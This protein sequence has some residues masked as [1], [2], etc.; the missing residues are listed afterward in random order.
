MALRL[1]TPLAG[2]AVTRPLAAGGIAGVVGRGGPAKGTAPLVDHE[3]PDFRLPAPDGTTVELKQLRRKAVLLNFWATWYTPCK[4]ELPNFEDVYRRHKE[5]GF[6]L[7]GVRIDS[8]AAARGVP[9]YMREGGSGVGPYTFPESLDT[10]Q[11]L[12]RMCRLADVPSTFFI[13]G[14]ALIR[15]LHPGALN[16]QMMMEHLATTVPAAA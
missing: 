5:Q 15:A 2:Y 13:D 9:A 4:E 11:E 16:R 3:A 14:D 1:D 7:L 8:E 6:V 10:R 12:A